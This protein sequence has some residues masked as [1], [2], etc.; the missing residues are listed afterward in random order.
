LEVDEAGGVAR[1]AEIERRAQPPDSMDELLA[2]RAVGR[3]G[4][5]HVDQRQA[6]CGGAGGRGSP[7]GW[8]GA[9]P[10]PAGG[11]PRRVAPGGRARIRSTSVF[12]CWDPARA[13]ATSSSGAVRPGGNSVR[14][15]AST[16]YALALLGSSLALGGRNLID[17]N[18]TPSAISA[19]ALT[20][21]IR[22]GR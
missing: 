6:G 14:S 9:G 19:V 17:A 12:S 22:P 18:G 3:R 8:G 13:P 15:A 10:C 11:L 20:S 4:G 2:G 5:S 7:G 21:A 1:D 16:R